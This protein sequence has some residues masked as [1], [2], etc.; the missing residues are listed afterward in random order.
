V[1]TEIKD[2]RIDPG[3]TLNPEPESPCRALDFG[4]SPLNR[5]RNVLRLRRSSTLIGPC[6]LSAQF[7]GKTHRSYYDDK[8]TGELAHGYCLRTHMALSPMSFGATGKPT[9]AVR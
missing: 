2:L 1:D 8:E 6:L 7:G 5:W 4:L 9:P 3:T